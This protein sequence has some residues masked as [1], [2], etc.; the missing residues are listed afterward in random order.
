M[1]EQIVS[2]DG[3][4][5]RPRFQ[6][7]RGLRRLP[8]ANGE[9]DQHCGQAAG[10]AP[11]AGID[12]LV[13]ELKNPS[14]RARITA[15][16][17]L[18]SAA[19]PE[20]AATIAGALADPDDS[21][22]Q[23]A[24]DALLAIY[25]V[26]G[27]LSDRQ[28]GPGSNGRTATRPEVAFEAGPLATMPAPV[29]PEALTGLASLVRGDESLLTRLSAAY[30]LGTLGAPGMG[31]L[32][33][34]AADRVGAELV[35]A[36]AHPDIATRQVVARIIGRVFA[37]VP[38]RPVPIAVGDAVIHAM[39]DPDPLVRRWAMD[40]LGW[41]RY[42]R[43]APA[44]TERF[45]FYRK[46]EEAAAALHA[47]ARIGSPD[48]AP[49]LRA[50]LGSSSP[51]FRVI[52]I[53]GLGRINDPDAAGDIAKAT[54]TPRNASVALAAAFAQFLTGQSSDI[55]AIAA[56]L[57]RPDTAVQARVY[58]AEI[59][60]RNPEA[61]HALLRSPDPWLRR[62][63]V[64]LIGVSRQPTQASVIEPMLHDN[65]AEVI[66][67]TSEALR[68]LRAYAAATPVLRGTSGRPD[69]VSK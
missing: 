69:G 26:H 20:S 41:L 35:A 29:P 48:S 22:Q 43:A 30:T 28:W 58:L 13:S 32:P 23:A 15:L 44:L 31:P 6:R 66:E 65:A 57:S 3:G 9:C 14:A 25:T 56:G 64:E 27:D 50:Q 18:A 4:A 10:Q 62:G 19:R 8:G 11:E 49:I 53:E 61:L 63:T 38:G 37:P 33:Q 54:A 45:E 5:S 47:L 51:S 16:Q 42:E 1:T 2:R 60:E 67:A 46:G 12:H 24:I 21:V 59:G 55:T 39:N 40:S 68:R 36:L 52:A 34:A 17:G 7:T